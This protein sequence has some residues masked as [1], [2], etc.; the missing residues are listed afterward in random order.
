MTY[1]K[2]QHKSFLTLFFVWCWLEITRK[3]KEAVQRVAKWYQENKYRKSIYDLQ[4]RMRTKIE[5]SH[6]QK[7]WREANRDRKHKLD[8]ALQKRRTK[9]DPRFRLTRN[10]RN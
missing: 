1:A 6:Y 3:R 5:R 2:I 4:Y 9:L 7:I 8:L 10:L